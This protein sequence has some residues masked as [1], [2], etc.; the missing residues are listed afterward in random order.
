MTHYLL[1]ELLNLTCT[2]FDNDFYSVL[3]NICDALFE[4]NP[5]CTCVYM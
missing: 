4:T 1:K 2:E 5:T 3:E